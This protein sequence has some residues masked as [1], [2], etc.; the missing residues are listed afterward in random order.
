MSETSSSN[1]FHENSIWREE[2]G[3]VNTAAWGWGVWGGSPSFSMGKLGSAA[4]AQKS[5]ML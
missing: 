4:K 1:T 2:R 5:K 3:S